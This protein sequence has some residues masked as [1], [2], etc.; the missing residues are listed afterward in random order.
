MKLKIFY[1]IFYFKKIYCLGKTLIILLR[2][3]FQNII[4]WERLESSSRDN[5]II[6]IKDLIRLNVCDLDVELNLYICVAIYI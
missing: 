3:N 5:S 2:Q 6:F 4:L 1:V